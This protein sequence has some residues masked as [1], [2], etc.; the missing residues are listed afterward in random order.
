MVGSTMNVFMCVILAWLT[1]QY[2]YEQHA[3]QG[4]SPTVAAEEPRF[5]GEIISI[6]TPHLCST[7]QKDGK[8]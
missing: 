8:F 6:L 4:V 5:K 2:V 1:P 3:G 7:V